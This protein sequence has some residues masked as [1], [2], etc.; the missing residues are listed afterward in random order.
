MNNQIKH[1]IFA[2]KVYYI[3]IL[4]FAKCAYSFAISVMAPVRNKNKETKPDAPSVPSVAENELILT[5]Y[6]R[7]KSYNRTA[8]EFGTNAMRVKRL[9]ER[10]SEDERR[11]YLD[12]AE[13]TRQVLR[14]SINRSDIEAVEDFAGTIKNS[15]DRATQELYDRLSP[16]R[17][18]EMSDKELINAVRLLNSIRSGEDDDPSNPHATQSIFALMDMSLND[19]MTIKVISEKVK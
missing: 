8:K 5:C 2:I 12:A 7:T 15:L 3:I 6:A 16:Q 11:G 1:Y 17:V 18:K 9:W 13:E 19:N 10:L 4:C 14:E